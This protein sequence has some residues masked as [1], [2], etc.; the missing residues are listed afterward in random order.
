MIVILQSQSSRANTERKDHTDRKVQK[1]RTT[2]T[3]KYRKPVY[4]RASEDAK[5]LPCPENNKCPLSN[6]SMKEKGGSHSSLALPWGPK[7][8]PELNST[9]SSF[10]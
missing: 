4:K 9:F 5:I 3:E 1:E 7:V 10:E 2:Q 6:H 8:A